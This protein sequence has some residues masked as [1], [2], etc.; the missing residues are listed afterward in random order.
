LGI[1]TTFM[2]CLMPLQRI[3]GVFLLVGVGMGLAW[4]DNR[5][6]VRPNRWALLFH[7][8]GSSSGIVLWQLHLWASSMP[9]KLSATKSVKAT[10]LLAS[11]T[12]YGFVLGR[13]L[14]PFPITSLHTLP[15][16]LWVIVL[17]LF[18]WVLR[19]RLHSAEEKKQALLSNPS[20][21]S[22]RMLFMALVVSICFLAIASMFERIGSGM[23]EAER[24]LTPLY[25]PVI[26]LVL[27]TWPANKRWAIK[28]GPGLLVVWT[29]YQG[30]RVG[31]N[32]LQLRQLPPA[33][34]DVNIQRLLKLLK[35]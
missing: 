30:I 14:V 1:V 18:L 20:V 8:L 11:L 23:H 24:Y 29:L 26:L 3:A 13:W 7:F 32:A 10:Q 5:R 27:L 33:E 15:V 12:D 4:T 21:V 16:L 2:G 22:S 17:G 31:H 34:A 28:L 25:P 19:P 9:S 6:L 35:K